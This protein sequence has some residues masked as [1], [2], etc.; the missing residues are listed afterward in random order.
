M[1]SFIVRPEE[2]AVSEFYNKES[3]GDLAQYLGH[4]A[5][6]RGEE[7]QFFNQTRDDISTNE[8]IEGIDRNVKGL[9]KDE[10]KFHSLF[11][12]PSDDELKHIGSDPEKLKEFTREAMENYAHN[13]TLKDDKKIKSEDLVWFATIHQDRYYTNKDQKMSEWVSEKKSKGITKEEIVKELLTENKFKNEENA[14]KRAEQFFDIGKV[15]NKEPKPGLNT[16]IH[17]VVSAR[18]KN[19]KITLHPTG[20]SSR[21][22]RTEWSKKNIVTFNAKY[23]YQGSL[24]TFKEGKANLKHIEKKVALINSYL[25]KDSKI[26]MEKVVEIGKKTEYNKQFYSRLS[27]TGFMLK[28][29]KVVN[30]PYYM[31]ET[32]KDLKPVEI[33]ATEYVVST[34]EELERKYGNESQPYEDMILP[35][36]RKR[37]KRINR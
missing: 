26:E 1:Y 9:T 14:Q 29:N 18:D 19:Q 20:K 21:F 23:Q 22:Q 5:K 27:K 36:N 4:D 3:V 28:D 31:I 17:I 12:N 35:M 16:H 33:K 10:D 24:K 11:I 30:D 7:T 37:K 32:G 25:P 15:R 8:L 6:E 2:H 13:F 34:L